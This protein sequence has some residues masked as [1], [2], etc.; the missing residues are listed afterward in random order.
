MPIAW[1][2][3]RS[4]GAA[5]RVGNCGGLPKLPGVLRHKSGGPTSQ[6]MTKRN[7]IAWRRVRAA[8]R[9][10]LLGAVVVGVMAAAPGAL[11]EEWS[12]RDCA[13]RAIGIEDS[14]EPLTREERLQQLDEAFNASLDRF[15]ECLGDSGSYSAS[16]A[17]SAGGGGGGGSAGGGGSGGGGGGGV[18]AAGVSGSG[19]SGQPG[20]PAQSDAGKPA[21]DEAAGEEAVAARTVAGTEAEQPEE[22]PAE[23]E[24]SAALTEEADGEPA[25]AEPADVP[26]ASGAPPKDIPPGNNDSVLAAQIRRAAL[27]AEDPVKRARLWNQYRNLKGLPEKPV[28]SPSEEES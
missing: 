25:D 4:G 12:K 19:Q 15:E 8:A 5:R 26:L 9:P 3:P 23:D 6:D 10:G 14:G 16:G 28:P 18:A 20:Q 11:A 24:Q 13:P 21:E 7:T 1:T 22:P 17:G 2:Q 27:A